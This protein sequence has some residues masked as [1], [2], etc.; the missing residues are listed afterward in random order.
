VS[1]SE[2]ADDGLKRDPDEGVDV[3]GWVLLRGDM[4]AD[5]RQGC[6]EHGVGHDADRSGIILATQPPAERLEFALHLTRRPAS[7]SRRPTQAT[8]DLAS[9]ALSSTLP[10]REPRAGR[11]DGAPR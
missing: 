2:Q 10:R 4:S 9:E 11:G 5:G 6:L 8:R 7:G 1:R 3:R